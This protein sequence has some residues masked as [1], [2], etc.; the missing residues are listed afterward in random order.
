MLLWE[1]RRGAVTVENAPGHGHGMSGA[2]ESHFNDSLS[3]SGY[4]DPLL[5]LTPDLPRLPAIP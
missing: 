3:L 2:I 1:G 5:G 4:T